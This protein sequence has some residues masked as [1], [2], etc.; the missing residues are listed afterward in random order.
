[1][2]GLVTVEYPLVPTALMACTRN[3]YVEANVCDGCGGYPMYEVT[4]YPVT[5]SSTRG[6]GS[7][8]AV[9][10]QIEVEPGPEG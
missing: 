7:E 6:P 10:D 1:M 4:T 3:R 9:D 2:T 5:Q 8:H